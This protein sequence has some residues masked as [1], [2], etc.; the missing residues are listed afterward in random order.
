MTMP[1]KP[2]HFE[3]SDWCQ[4]QSDHGLTPWAIVDASGAVN[5]KALTSRFHTSDC[6]NLLAHRTS[7]PDVLALAPRML[8]MRTPASV[9]PLAQWFAEQAIDEPVVFFVATPLTTDA[10][11]LAMQHRSRVKLAD[12]E[13][14]LLRWW[15]AR[16][17][18][19]LNQALA[20]ETPLN[21]AFFGA[22]AESVYLSRDG[23]LLVAPHQP[24]Q[25]DVLPSDWSLSDTS[26]GKLLELGT[27][28]AILGICREDYG[29][30][31]REVPPAQRY[32][33]AR[34]Q[35][36]WAEKRGFSSPQDHALATRIAATEGA[37]WTEVEP[38]TELIERALNT[39][40]TLRATLAALNEIDE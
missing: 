20:Q 16:I 21:A 34:E 4:Q 38:W 1:P 10:F 14:M 12:G 9:R 19:A 24:T 3:L 37:N 11:T 22:L 18:W 35:W 33:L 17:W 8:A 29:D 23:G 2:Q 13:S 31:L 15:D 27:P 7:A 6:V 36:T 5:I 32:A 28:D 26:L 30:A 39:E 40:Q 25:G